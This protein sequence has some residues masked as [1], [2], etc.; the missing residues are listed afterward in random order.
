ML[1][2]NIPKVNTEVP[3]FWYSFF[4]LIRF[5]LNFALQL[6]PFSTDFAISLKYWF[7]DKNPQSKQENSAFNANLNQDFTQL[8]LSPSI[9][10]L[11]FNPL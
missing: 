7:E 5:F 4:F 8:V 2:T 1:V 9:S 6:H 11:D 10:Q 3:S